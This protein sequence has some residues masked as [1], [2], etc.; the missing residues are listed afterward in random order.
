MARFFEENFA[1]VALSGREA[2]LA[3]IHRGDH[4]E[5]DGTP[6]VNVPESDP[7]AAVNDPAP[8]L[9]NGV[10]AVADIRPGD[11]LVSSP[12]PG[13]AMRSDD[14][15]LGTVIGKAL[16]ALGHGTGTIRALV[17]MR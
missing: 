4:V 15:Q 7:A 6:Q 8:D 2:I 12:T 17:M 3:F 14:P 11:L 5:P 10:Q 1:A 16:E 13:H 9:R